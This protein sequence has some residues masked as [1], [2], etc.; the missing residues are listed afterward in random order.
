VEISY[1]QPLD[2]FTTNIIGTLNLLECLKNYKNKISVVI[3]TSDKSYKNIEQIWGY[4][5]ND[6]FGG[7][8]PY[9]S[10]KAATELVLMGY[11]HSFFQNKNNIRIAIARAGNVIGGGDWSLSRLVPDAIKSWSKNKTLMVRNPNATRPWQH[12]LEPLSGYLYLAINIHEN[13]K[14]NLESFNFGPKFDQNYSVKTLLKK[15][16]TYWKNSKISIKKIPSFKE[17]SLLKLNCEKADLFLGW[18][19]ILTFNDNIFLTIDW[20]IK[21]LNGKEDD[22]LE[23]TKKQ[24]DYYVNLRSD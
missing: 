23:I 9:S 1:K 7:T 14:C 6:I 16:S 15:A 17:S 4:K 3:I 12:V 10:S 24:I 22:I 18:K 2:T 20:Y 21:Y 13:S 8:D 5:E 19:P 11:F